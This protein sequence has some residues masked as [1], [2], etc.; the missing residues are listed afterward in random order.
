MKLNLLRD[1]KYI[2]EDTFIY[3]T[4]SYRYWKIFHSSSGIWAPEVIL[5]TVP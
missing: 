2:K 4:V 1:N 3:H 5:A